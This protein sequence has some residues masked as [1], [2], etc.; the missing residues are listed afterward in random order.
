MMEARAASADVPIGGV[1]RIEHQLKPSIPR[2]SPRSP[3]EWLPDSSLPFPVLKLY[4]GRSGRK[5]VTKAIV[6]QLKG[7][8]PARLETYHWG[9][10]G[11]RSYWR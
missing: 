9:D 2:R 1:S 3:S 10:R 8:L 11:F 5:E 6:G 4:L 7:T